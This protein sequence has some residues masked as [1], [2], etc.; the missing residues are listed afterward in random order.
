[1]WFVYM[2]CYSVA[3]TI[4]KLGGHRCRKVEVAVFMNDLYHSITLP[5]CPVWVR[6]TYGANVRLAKFCMPVYQMGFTTPAELPSI[7]EKKS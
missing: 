3:N 1:M 2:A 7:S 6:T 5:L 4:F